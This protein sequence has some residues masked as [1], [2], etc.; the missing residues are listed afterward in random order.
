MYTVKNLRFHKG[1]EGEPCAQ[2]SVYR[3]GRKVAEYSDDEHGG[4]PRFMWED[5]GKPR[6][7]FK[8]RDW[9][10]NVCDRYGTEEEARMWAHCLTRP[11]LVMPDFPEPLPMSPDLLVSELVEQQELERA[12]KAETK[13][14]LRHCKTKLLFRV[15]GDKPGSWR[16][17]ALTPSC[18]L[19]RARKHVCEKYGDKL[20]EILNG[21]LSPE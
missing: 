1:H 8:A 18:D 4:E 12:R 19:A 13:R 6:A 14:L 2:C 15:A 7:P 9:K 3:D 5:S 21:R 16:T 20:E 11:D 17:I 10:G